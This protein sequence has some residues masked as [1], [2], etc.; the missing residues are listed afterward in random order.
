[1]PLPV[2]RHQK[3]LEV[4][5]MLQQRLMWVLWPAFLAAGVLEVLVFA[6]IDPKDLGWAGAPLGWSRETVYTVA[7][8]V[9]WGVAVVSNGLTA[10]LAMPATEV[11]R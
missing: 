1:M 9:F 4:A 8:F 7:F 5:R 3:L 10:L 11:N 6:L 2:L